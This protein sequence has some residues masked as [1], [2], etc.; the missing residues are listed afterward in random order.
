MTETLQLRGTLRSAAPRKPI[1][2]AVYITII[3]WKMVSTTVFSGSLTIK[4]ILD[5]LQRLHGKVSPPLLEEYPEG[6]SP[7]LE[8]PCGSSWFT[9]PP[10]GITA[11]TRCV[12]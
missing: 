6:S 9:V 1:N 2:W 3:I 7:L 10:E 8:E 11:I 12:L 5:P 4:A